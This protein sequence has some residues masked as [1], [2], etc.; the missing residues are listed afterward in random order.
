MLRALGKDPLVIKATRTDA[1]YGMVNLM[2]E[3]YTAV[4][5]LQKPVLYLYGANDEVI[6]Q[7]ATEIAL[8]RFSQ[9]ISFALYPKGYHMLLR[10]LQHEIVLRD[11]ASWIT[12]PSQP[13]PSGFAKEIN[14]QRE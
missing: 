4:P 10:D 12:A 13:L 6:V 7:D 2:D 5:K 8:A 11:I 9:P 1:I 3:A 14:P